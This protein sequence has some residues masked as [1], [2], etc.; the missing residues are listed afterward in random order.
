MTEPTSTADRA[1]E[2]CIA[3][4]R[5]SIMTRPMRLRLASLLVVVLVGLAASAS[6]DPKPAPVDI[7]PFRDQ[8][9]VLQD[10]QGGTYVVLPGSSRRVFYGTGKTLYEQVVENGSSNGETGAW[11]IGVWAPRVPDTSPGIVQR[12]DAGVF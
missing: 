6:A 11:S 10:A 3:I 12:N 9:I 4:P 5:P 7:K 8:L 1:G 2:S